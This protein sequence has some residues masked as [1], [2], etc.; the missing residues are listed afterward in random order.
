MI[1][2]SKSGLG[3]RTLSELIQFAKS[4]QLTYASAGNG[5]IGHLTGELFKEKV[6]V[7]LLHIPYK[8]GAPA[9]NDLLGGQVD[10]IFETAQFMS[11]Q[12]K[13]GAVTAFAV[14]GNSRYPGLPDVPTVNEILGMK[15]VE[16]YSW[17]GLTAPAQ[18]P[19]EVILTL[20]RALMS[21]MRD[22]E[23]K[24]QLSAI[25]LESVESDAADMKNT[26]DTNYKTWHSL[27]QR[28]N[29]KPE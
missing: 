9:L 26:I 15:G 23:L 7:D 12:V 29:I 6:Q 28:K 14:I 1:L 10:L 8:G 22:S 5:S 16:A 11:S 27:V 4:H 19:K 21:V 2:A 3:P 18:T 24:S 25:G 17:F 13:S 20:E